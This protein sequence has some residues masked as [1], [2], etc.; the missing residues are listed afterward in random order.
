MGR[1]TEKLSRLRWAFV[2]Y[3]AILVGVDVVAGWKMSRGWLGTWTGGWKLSTEAF[4]AVFFLVSG[5]LFALGFWLFSLLLQKKNGAR[6]VLLIV[7]WLAVLDALSSWVFTSGSG[8][9]GSWLAGLAPGLAWQ[10]VFLVDRIKDFLGLF[11]WGYAIY[12]LQVD[13]EVKR[14]FLA[15]PADASGTGPSA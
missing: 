4:L 14:E 2:I 13:K 15:L 11:F 8:S 5:L 6:I 9:F 10:K 7:G 3:F 1:F 12:V